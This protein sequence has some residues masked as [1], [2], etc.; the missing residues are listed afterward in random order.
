M[1]PFR[2]VLSHRAGRI[3]VALFGLAYLVT[4]VLGVPAVVSHNDQWV[5]DEFKRVVSRGGRTD[6]SSSHPGFN[7]LAAVPA[8][9]G[10]VISLRAYAIAGRYGWGGVQ[11]DVWW[12]GAVRPWFKITLFVS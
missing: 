1:T 12:P 5:V 3:A 7:T 6:V 9:P 2:S 4:W 8:F 10:L 11:A